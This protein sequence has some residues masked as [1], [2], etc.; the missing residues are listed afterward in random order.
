VPGKVEELAEV[1]PPKSGLAVRVLVRA[2]WPAFCPGH[3]SDEW[4]SARGRW[5]IVSWVAKVVLGSGSRSLAFRFRLVVKY[6]HDLLGTR[7]CR[8]RGVGD[9]KPGIGAGMLLRPAADDAPGTAEAA[10]TRAIQCAL[11]RLCKDLSNLTFE[12]TVRS[13]RGRGDGNAAAEPSEARRTRQRRGAALPLPNR[14]REPVTMISISLRIA[15]ARP[16]EAST[17]ERLLA[18]ALPR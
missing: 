17:T 5:R 12:E 14:V 8:G 16:D 6:L 13:R 18:W 9:E 4:S 2:L 3:R 7:L 11:P 15:V 10:A 1:G